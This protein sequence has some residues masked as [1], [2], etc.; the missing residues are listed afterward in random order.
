MRG[1]LKQHPPLLQ[2]ITILGFYAG[3]IGVFILL[4]ALLTPKLTG[5]TAMEISEGVLTDPKF[6]TMQKWLQFFYTTLTYL[7]PAAIFAYLWHPEPMRYLGLKTKA[8][9]LQI[10]LTIALFFC[11]LPVVGVL[12]Q[13]NLQWDLPAAALG[14]QQRN[15]QMTKA[16]LQMPA[17]TDLLMNLILMAIVPAIAEEVF[18]RGVFQRIFINLTR[19]KWTG[20]LVTAVIFAAM[21]FE[22]QAVLPRI[23]LGFILGTI[24]LV[25]GNLWLAILAH[26]INNGML[27]IQYYLFQHG[28][29]KTDP[30]VEQGVEWYLGLASAVVTVGLI[31][32]LMKRSPEP[33]E[34]E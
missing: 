33:L 19:L 12:A 20:V 3:S 7:L 34:V 8:S 4:T 22:M 31:W 23:A 29:I 28:Y 16:L 27:V 32:A 30:A 13:W 2:F 9:L 10:I 21:H 1:Y 5:Y 26:L 14:A 25:T 11:C 17:I 15:E 24:F 6:L 18:F